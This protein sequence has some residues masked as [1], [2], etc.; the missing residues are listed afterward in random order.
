M[1]NLPNSA[2]EGSNMESSVSQFNMTGEVYIQHV[3]LFIVAAAL[4]ACCRR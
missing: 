1:M 4:L 3:G 2:I